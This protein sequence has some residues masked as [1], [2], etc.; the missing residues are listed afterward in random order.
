MTEILGE[1]RRLCQFEQ[2]ASGMWLFVAVD[3]L[4]GWLLEYSAVL[5]E[6][7]LESLD[8]EFVDDLLEN[9]D[10]LSQFVFFFTVD[11]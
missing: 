6:L 7:V 3:G 10:F 2:V 5:G 9:V 11:L 1:R 4:F 8:S